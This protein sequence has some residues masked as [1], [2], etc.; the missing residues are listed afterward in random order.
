MNAKQATSQYVKFTNI[1]PPA[2]YL[3]QAQNLLLQVLDEGPRTANTEY[4]IKCLISC[5]PYI[6]YNI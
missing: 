1:S 3:W 5:L 2:L 4:L 6:A